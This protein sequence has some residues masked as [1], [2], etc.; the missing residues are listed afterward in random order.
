MLAEFPL[1]FPGFGNLSLRSRY[2]DPQCVYPPLQ[3]MPAA[4]VLTAEWFREAR[5]AQGFSASNTYFSQR[6]NRWISIPSHTV[7]DR[8]GRLR[9]FVKHDRIAMDLPDDLRTLLRDQG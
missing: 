9:L 6:T 7:L 3:V 4:A 2:G 8:D 1:I 5:V